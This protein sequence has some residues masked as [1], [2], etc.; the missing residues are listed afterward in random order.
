MSN[1]RNIRP[2]KNG[3]LSPDELQIMKE[4]C[5]PYRGMPRKTAV[6]TAILTQFQA[7]TGRTVARR[8]LRRPEAVPER[9]ALCLTAS[10]GRGRSREGAGRTT[11]APEPR[12]PVRA[13]VPPRTRNR[14]T[15]N[16]RSIREQI[17]RVR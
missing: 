13:E 5:D 8:T 4:V 14:A 1:A 2:R 16:G 15:F 7:R 6:I 10:R 9:R 12:A 17:R 11:P 3:P